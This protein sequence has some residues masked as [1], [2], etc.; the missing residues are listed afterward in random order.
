M[1]E[2]KPLQQSW[3]SWIDEQVERAEKE[4][5]FAGLPGAGKPIPGLD[6]PY[7]EDWWLREWL[8]R[9]QLSFTPEPIELRKKIALLRAELPR[10]RDERSFR[11]CVAA[12]N[13]L[14]GRVNAAPAPD[15]L[16]P[17]APLDADEELRDWRKG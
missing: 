13:A 5:A 15:A 10:Q 14:I 2:R 12:I 6:Q 8:E 9:E 4:G 16:A 3:R 1:G 11:A 17:L 7:H